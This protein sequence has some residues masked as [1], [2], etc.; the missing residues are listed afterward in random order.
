MLMQLDLCKEQ[1]YLPKPEWGGVYIPDVALFR[2]IQ[3]TDITP[4]WASVVYA[5]SP[6]GQQVPTVLREKILNV[7]R[8]CHAHGHEYVV[9]GAVD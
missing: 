6:C 5:A 4:F 7:L 3:G 8:I 1:K 2:D 9:L